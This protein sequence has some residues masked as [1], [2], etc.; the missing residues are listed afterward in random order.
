ML[1]YGLLL[2]YDS[3][4]AIFQRFVILKSDWPAFVS[5]PTGK[6]AR[7][8]PVGVEKG[9]ASSYAESFSRHEN[10]GIP[11]IRVSYAGATHVRSLPQSGDTPVSCGL[12]LERGRVIAFRVSYVIQKR[13]FSND[14]RF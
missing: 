6:Y 12:W 9:Y 2:P 7:F 10:G 11:T 4:T 8:L 14:L 1:R 13:P 5:A 3:K